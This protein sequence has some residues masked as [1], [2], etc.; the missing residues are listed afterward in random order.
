M[1][2][3]DIATYNRK[4][5]FKAT[6]EPSGKS[7]GAKG[8]G[9]FVI[10][11]HAASRLHYDFRLEWDGVL[12][13]WAV[14]KGPSLDPTIK[15]MAVQVEDHPVSYGTF[16]GTIPEGN[17]GAGSVIV[18]DRGVWQP[19]G[20]AAAGL[21][22]GKLKFVLA[23]EK[24]KGAFMLVRLHGKQNE[25]QPPWLLIKEKDQF[26]RPI[27]E[28]D[29]VEEMGDSV[30]NPPAARTRAK[31]GGSANAPVAPTAT[32]KATG[33]KKGRT[34]PQSKRAG[35]PLPPLMAPQLAT[36]VSAPPPTGEWDYELK[37]DGYRLL[38]RV[39]GK[40][41]RCFTRNG[42]DWT[43]RM[44]RVAEAVRALKL[45]PCW[46]DGELV[47][48]NKKG[49]PDFQLLQ[50]AFE[51]HTTADMRYLVFDLLF[52]DGED[53]RS[54][55]QRERRQRLR[56][57]LKGA[58]GTVQFS[59]TLEDDPKRLLAAAGGAGFEGLLGKRADATYA[60]GRSRDWIKLKVGLRQEF[61][62]GG[63]T[64]PQGS[65]T[66]L[67]SILLGVHD[68]GGALRYAGNV[69]TGFN[70]Q[71]LQELF[72]KLSRLERPTSP[73][74]GGPAKVGTVRKLVPHWVQPKLVAEIV[75][76][77]WTDNNHVR[78]GVFHGLREDKPARQI[79]LERPLAVG[80]SE[81]DESSEAAGLHQVAEEPM[82]KRA[83]SRSKARTKVVAENGAAKKSAAR[84]RAAKKSVS[85][86]GDIQ[87]VRDRDAAKKS[88]ARKVAAKNVVAK[89]AGIKSVA[90][91]SKSAPHP[92]TTSPP[93][94]AQAAPA[95]TGALAKLRI[96]HPERVID[97]TTGI[98][99]GQLIAYYAEIAEL[100]LPHLKERPVALL[101]APEGVAGQMF[102]QKH[103]EVRA[104]PEVDRLPPDL[105]TDHKSMLAVSTAAGLVSAAQM[106][107]IEF[108]TWNATTKAIEKPDRIIFDLDP[109][110]NVN[111]Q[112][113]VEGT[114]LIHSM[115]EE[116]KL[117]SF[118]KTSGG[119]G[120]HV[121]V[122]LKPALNWDDSKLFSGDLVRH[123]AK[124]LPQRFVAKSGPTNRVGRIFVDY[125]RN[126]RGATTA[127]GWSARA[128]PGMGI[129]VPLEWDELATLPEP[130]IWTVSNFAE[131]LKIGNTPWKDYERSRQT[132]DAA[133]KALGKVAAA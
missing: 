93:P 114:R 121:V 31:A 131:R 102:F 112:A 77:G 86:K 132:L 79:T 82:A 27:A 60:S 75:F 66:G 5:N 46:L 34:Q 52:H 68:K 111:W 12:R 26:A 64:D 110:E 83:Q 7:T 105:D 126:G 92:K 53:T 62:I 119:K 40:D 95:L 29:V 56:E 19:I 41:V 42:N 127:C 43:S 23:G 96:T 14:P 122:P 104:L 32:R 98:T 81:E 100:M 74:E 37:L 128:R 118:L 130:P 78:H 13:S 108:H 18:W 47:V 72:D 67:G 113:V 63:F 101:R 61:V 36:L 48:L 11:K 94:R 84:K 55:G 35:A 115:L 73:F 57:L 76:A 58:R 17:Y 80:A 22:E 117:K 59:E 20:D 116:L 107:V 49:V 33:K 24:L 91:R 123:M 39:D 51:H 25:R 125:L 133:V 28:F 88:V 103:A 97:P 21:S 30:I 124:V 44:P 15:R 54:L 45:E 109:G 1:A 3:G 8:A 69:G 85:K 71:T 2:A 38:V 4:R 65:R 6:P 70:Q 120:L 89:K 106:N 99:K 16:E 90:A 10:Q 129:S 87:S 50:N 9:S